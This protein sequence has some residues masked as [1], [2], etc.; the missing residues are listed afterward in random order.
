VD[1]DAYHQQL[2][3]LSPIGLAWNVDEG[4]EY[5]NILYAFANSLAKFDGQVNEI[6]LKELNPLTATKLLPEWERLLSLPDSCSPDNQT[7][8]QRREA[9][10]SRWIMKGGQSK[11]YFIALAKSLGYEITI[12]SYKPFIVGLSGCGDLL[13]PID[14]RFAWRVNVPGERAYYFRTGESACGERL[15]QIVPATQLECIFRKLQPSYSDLFFNY[16]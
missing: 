11:A 12:D 15:L 2:I 9:A 6:F 14:M 5:S 8:L 13:N 7:L 16:S 10:Y 3:A 4:S 1:V